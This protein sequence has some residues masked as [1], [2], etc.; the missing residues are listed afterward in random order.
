[1]QLRNAA[2]VRRYRAANLERVLDCGKKTDRKRYAKRRADP[3][4]VRN[5]TNA[6][7]A[8]NI[9]RERL[10]GRV[11]R[12]IRKTREVTDIYSADVINSLYKFQQGKCAAFWCST[13]LLDGYE[14]DHILA[15]SRGGSNKSEN[16]QLLCMTCNRSKAT[17][18]MFEF[19]LRKA[20]GNFVR[21]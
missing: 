1:M 4:K 7:R 11:N 21:I 10:R 2:A 6:W 15:L 17:K 12:N 14:I 13:D 19:Y 5:Y 20:G 3:Q 18:S 8:E 9:E 16:L